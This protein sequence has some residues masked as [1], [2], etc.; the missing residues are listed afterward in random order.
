MIKRVELNRLVVATLKNSAEMVRANTLYAN[1]RN[2]CP[3][4]LQ[5]ERVRGFRS[6][7]KILN[8]FDNVIAVGPGV[9]QYTYI[10]KSAHDSSPKT[11][12]CR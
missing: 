10:E 1:L 7:V 9:K 5:N 11:K 12:H 4:V 2:S 8:Q 6:F 3:D